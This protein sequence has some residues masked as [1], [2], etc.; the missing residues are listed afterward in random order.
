VVTVSYRCVPEPD[1]Q[2]VARLAGM[3]QLHASWREPTKAETAAAAAQL[4]EIAGGRGD[5][6]AEAAGL[7]IGFYGRTVEE[8]RAQAAARYCIAAGADPDLVPRWIE[9]GSRRAAAARQVPH[10][11]SKTD[12]A[13]ARP[14]VSEPPRPP[15]TAGRQQRLALGWRSRAG[16][17]RWRA[18]RYN[19]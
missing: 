6:L 15:S 8:C 7:L 5:L 1:R 13:D 16:R 11:G 18:F 2:M 10:A 17:N 12:G 9:V 4:R 19:V 3:A 14:E